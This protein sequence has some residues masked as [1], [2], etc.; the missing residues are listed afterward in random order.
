[1]RYVR[2]LK[3]PRIISDKCRPSPYIYCLITVTSDLGDSFLPYDTNLVA[4]LLSSEDEVLV[5]KSMKWTGGMRSLSIALPIS[6][7]HPVW[8][9][10]VRVG[11]SPKS[12]YDSFEDLREE[13]S[14][15]VIS[16]Y[17]AEIDFNK[18]VKEAVKFVE[19]RFITDDPSAG[20]LCIWEETGE[21]IARH[22]WYMIP[23]SIDIT[24]PKSNQKCIFTGTREQ[25]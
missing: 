10:R 22:V 14:R 8:P 21:S 12:R 11:V 19:R 23:L 16:A 1:M 7:S 25:H 18:G 20:T 17:S 15:G 9:V 3:P 6:K 5:W 4:E 24:G 13:G 2:L